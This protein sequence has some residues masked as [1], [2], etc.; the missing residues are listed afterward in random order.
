MAAKKKAKAKG[1][2]TRKKANKKAARK[3]VT[4]RTAKKKIGGKKTARSKSKKPRAVAKSAGAPAMAPK[5]VAAI[6][7]PGGT[8]VGTVTH[9][10]TH[11]GVAIVQ[12]ETGAL[13]EGD[14]VHIKGHTSD[15]SQRVESMEL[16]HAHVNEALAGQSVGLR[17]S[18]HAREHDIVY[19]MA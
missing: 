17:V 7:P 3:K 5:P 1:K 8:R 14:M 15:F 2:K 13:R 4:R 19:K 10:F 16:D 6:A 18:E 11:L 12:L 9:Y